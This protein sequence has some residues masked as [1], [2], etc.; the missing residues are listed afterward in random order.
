MNGGQPRR[1]AADA[2]RVAGVG[3][4]RPSGPVRSGRELAFASWSPK[5]TEVWQEG[6]RIPAVKL[7]D[8]GELRE[9][10]IE[11]ILTASRLPDGVGLDIRAKLRRLRHVSRTA[12]APGTTQP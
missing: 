9:D 3:Q 4:R 11:M 5:A 2:C 8:G 7:V 6:L 12:R 1:K 10:V